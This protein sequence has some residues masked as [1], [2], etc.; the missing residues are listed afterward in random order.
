MTQSSSTLDTPHASQPTS[1]APDATPPVRT[2]RTVPFAGGDDLEDEHGALCAILHA[3]KAAG[4]TQA[5]VARHMG[6]TASAVSRLEGSLMRRRH[7]PSFDTLRKYAAA[8]GKK[9]VIALR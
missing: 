2:H 4:L 1:P 9:L 6:T 8:C 5:Q 3:R 7:S